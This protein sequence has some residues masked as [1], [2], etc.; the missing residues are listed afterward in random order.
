[1]KNQLSL[2]PNH[3]FVPIN[4]NL[5]N[6]ANKLLDA[7]NDGRNEKEK[8]HPQ[9]YFQEKQ[10]IVLIASNKKKEMVCNI[11]DLD[12]NIPSDFSACWRSADHIKQELKLTI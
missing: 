5:S 12:G 7:L 9:F 10:F 1:M 3:E 6:K 4:E 2:F 8:F 11:L